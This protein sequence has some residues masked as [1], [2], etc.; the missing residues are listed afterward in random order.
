MNGVDLFVDTNVLI[1]LAEGKKGFDQY[2]EGNNIF[3]SVISE[4][5]LLGWHKITTHQ[6]QF[7]TKL[8]ED[9]SIVGLISPVKELSIELKQKHKIKLPDAVIAGS[10]LHLD[11]PL[12]TLDRGFEKIK[13]LNL[14]I[15]Y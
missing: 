7:F 13:N 14:M 9:C 11:I 1:S 12:L 15:I 3:V 8:L 2:L 4:I 5:E 6:K 10:A